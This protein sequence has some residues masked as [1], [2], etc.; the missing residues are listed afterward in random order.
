MQLGRVTNEITNRRWRT[1]NDYAPGCHVM[2]AAATAAWA[3][4]ATTAGWARSDAA[5]ATAA[6]SLAVTAAI[7]FRA[8]PGGMALGASSPQ[9][10]GT[11][12]SW[13]LSAE[14]SSLVAC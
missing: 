2:R 7:F 6:R 11:L 8:L 12:D 10:L 14:R 13:A 4:A 5:T 9:S 1:G 3:A